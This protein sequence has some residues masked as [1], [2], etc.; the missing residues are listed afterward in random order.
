MNPA[1][2]AGVLRTEAR[3]ATDQDLMRRIAGQDEA[4]FEEFFLRHRAM[5]SARAGRICR[6]DA[7]AEDITQ[8]TFLRVWSR[9]RQWKGSGS[10]QAWL[11]RIASNLA[12][13]RLRTVRRRKDRPAGQ[14]S[15]GRAQADLCDLADDG[16][17]GPEE[18]VSW[19]ER[20]RMLDDAVAGLSP[21]KRRTWELVYEEQ[22]SVEATADLLDV[23][24]GTIKSRLFHARRR[25]AEAW[26]AMEEQGETQR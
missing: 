26:Q 14:S 13:N 2:A 15:D 21:A 12:I 9:A 17:S 18:L 19:A 22:M 25:I 20:R 7:A 10:I 16:A 8:E 24:P 1:G 23:S 3:M 11:V 6:D 5:V 4:A